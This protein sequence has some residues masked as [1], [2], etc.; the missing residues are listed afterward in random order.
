[1][2]LIQLWVGGD[3]GLSLP[4]RGGIGMAPGLAAQP[5]NFL[6]SP[7]LTCAY[8]LESHVAVVPRIVVHERVVGYLEALRDN[9]SPDH[10][11][12]MGATP[13]RQCRSMIVQ[14]GD[15]FMLDFYGPAMANLIHGRFSAEQSALARRFV[16]TSLEDAR[17]NLPPKVVE[18]YE[19]LQKYLDNR[20]HFW[21]QLQGTP[22]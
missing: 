7:A 13:G 8:D 9:P 2:A 16:A 3:D 15:E 10:L 22:A 21:P 5:E 18:K 1:M 14:D 4:L 19:W 17:A 6:Y 20:A 11:D 12:Q